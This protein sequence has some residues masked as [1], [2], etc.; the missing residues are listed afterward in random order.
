MPGSMTLSAVRSA[1]ATFTRSSPPVA[2]FVGGTSGI[3]QA[4]ATAFAKLTKGN[5][6][7]IICGRNRAAAESIIASF[8]KY[9]TD[10]GIQP[11]HEFVQCDVTLMK[12][13]HS[14]TRGLLSRLPKLNFLV[15]SPGILTLKGRDETDEGIDRK[16]ALH[17]Y[18]RWK[19]T[20]DLL[21]LLRKAK[22]VGE[23]AKMITV[24]GAGY[25]GKVYLDDLGLKSNYSLANAGNV[26]CSYNDM[27]VQEFGIREPDI[28][29]THINPGAVRTSI[30]Q[31]SHWPLRQLAPIL[32]ILIYPLSL[33]P[34]D[35]AEYMLHALFEGN[36]GAFRRGSRGELI[37]TENAWA[38][39][40]TRKKVWEHSIEVTSVTDV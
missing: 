18:A 28:A 5:A 39:E 1:N 26:G 34:E 11:L 6:H 36:K 24:L 30:M 4:M 25:G 27:M 19:I 38:N 15:L 10:Q 3:G 37:T 12:N 32:A 17:Y 23:D 13:V 16:L 9:T 21:P 8:P 40:E 2:M 20:N 22:D 29:F 35:C 31:A 14:M 7:I 33:S